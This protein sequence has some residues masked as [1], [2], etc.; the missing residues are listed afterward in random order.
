MSNA[1]ITFV[2]HASVIFSHKDIRLMTDPWL[3]GS[4]FNNGWEL[5]SKSKFQLNDFA[6][7]THIWFSHEHADH[8]HPGVLSKIPEDLR[9][10]I[11]ILFQDT[12]DHRVAKKCMQLNFKSVIE[13]IPNEYIKLND[14]F[15]IKCVPNGTYDSWFYAQIGEHKILNIN[16]CMVDSLS[17][18]KIIKKN[19]SNVDIL[20]TQFGY[21]SWVGDPD[22]VQL[23]KNASLEKLER[24]KI[25]SKIFT[26]KFIIPFASFVRF[27]HKDNF[28]MNDE[29]NQ[30]QDVENFI[31]SKTNSIPVILYPGDE[32]LGKNKTDN[33]IAIKNY[34]LDLEKNKELYEKID[35]IEDEKLQNL[36]LSY[37][38]NI[39][40]RNNWFFITLLHKIGFFK[41]TT[42]FLNDK[43]LSYKFNLIDGLQKFQIKKSKVDIIT[44][45]DSLGFVFSWDYGMDS[46]FVN[47]RF[48]TSGGKVMNFFRLFLI[49][50]LNNNGRTFPMGVIGFLFNEKS[51]WK[52]KFLEIILGKFAIK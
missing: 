31:L 29:M 13:M 6:K 18:A 43:N 37:V 11:T 10:K 28:Y 20:L 27:S 21:A 8:F 47:A 7:I 3:F 50:T 46:L 23:R 41:T 14:E 12:L 2:N 30:I 26:P 19:I 15:K 35:L 17:Q 4:A 49:G 38:E 22:D 33:S 51:M 42:I 16:D 48:R 45:S 34:Q 32:W 52:T 40:K 36:A 39:K 9:K 24:I 44:D 25:Q 5:L 1:L